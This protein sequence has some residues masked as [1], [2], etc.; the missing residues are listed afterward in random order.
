MD[1]RQYFRLKLCAVRILF[2]FKTII[3]KGK[4]CLL[5]SSGRKN[6]VLRPVPERE[7]SDLV[8]SIDT[9]VTTHKTTYY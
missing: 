3:G 8:C 5:A 6:I 1:I 4:L 7:N 2:S 9:L